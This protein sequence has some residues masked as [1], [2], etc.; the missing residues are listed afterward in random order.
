MTVATR[1]R[2]HDPA[3][4][5]TPSQRSDRDTTVE[6]LPNA[7][8]DGNVPDDAYQSYTRDQASR[9]SEEFQPMNLSNQ[10]CAYLLL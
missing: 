9:L 2:P 6:F 10:T 3:V 1:N 4:K 7:T 5:R 8:C